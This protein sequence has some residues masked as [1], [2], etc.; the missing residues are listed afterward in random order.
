MKY[1]VI[2]PVYNVERQLNRCLDS[3]AHQNRDDLEVIIVDDGSTDGSGMICDDYAGKYDNFNVIHQDNK[4]LSGARNAGLEIAGGEW[5]LFLDADD[6]WA[7]DYLDVIDETIRKHPSEYYKFNYEKVFDDRKPIRNALIVENEY[8]ELA[9]EADRLSFL[10]DRVLVYSVG[11]EAHTGVYKKSLIDEYC[12]RFTDT[13]RVFAEDMLFTME[14]IL[15]VRNAYL[16]CNFLYMY[17]T[18]EGSLS[19]NADNDTVLPRLYNLLGIFENEIRQYKVLR[20]NFFR[21]YFHIVNF[22]VK[23]NLKD[24]AI[25]TLIAQIKELDAAKKYSKFGK[26]IKKDRTLCGYIMYGRN[27]L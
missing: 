2:I 8:I 25:D 16:I 13:K 26:L 4:G 23:Y 14:Y 5:I 18:R 27:W 24:V 21:V 1:S 9:E 6:Y 15:H 3:V 19:I 10:T 7:E 22:H 12:I 17:Y 11:W 20:K